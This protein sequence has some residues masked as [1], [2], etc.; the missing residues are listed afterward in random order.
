MPI[1]ENKTT[2]PATEAT[3]DLERAMRALRTLGAVNR[4]QAHAADEAGFLQDVC[5]A[6]VEHGYR[7]AWV[8]YAQQD[9]E[10]TIRPVAHAGVDEG[11]LESINLTWGDSAH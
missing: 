3:G 8:G 11:F 10:K 9:A 5:T 4:A 2:A 7:M 1:Q 6:I